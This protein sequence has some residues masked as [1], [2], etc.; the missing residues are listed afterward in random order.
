MKDCKK[1]RGSLAAYLCEDL[2]ADERRLLEQ[3]LET[4]PAC[5][6]ESIQMQ[7]VLEEADS[8]RADIQTAMASVDWRT[9]PDRISDKVFSETAPPA[10]L[11]RMAR[12]WGYIIQPRLRPVY[13]AL[14]IGV[15]LG[16]A[17]T[18]VVFRSPQSSDLAGYELIVPQKVL[19]AMDIEMARRETL[20]YL[21]K[22]Q[23]LLLD[24]VQSSPE[25]SRRSWQKQFTS[26]R[27]K[28][29]L[30]KKKYLNQQL[31]KF[32][33][34]KAKAICDQI[35]FLFFE[36]TQISDELS[37]AEIE[38][39]QKLIDERQLLLKIKLIQK[40]IEESEV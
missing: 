9:L 16:A 37:S 27:A 14:F 7:K 30:S 22:S 31:N 39:I 25:Y 28:E 20:D 40:E 5:Q 38:R 36:L 18:V 32:Q 34:A 8:L 23:Y 29:L 24:F 11:S 13:A 10:R 1:F 26:E 2:H 3:H 4:C 35:E 17:L 15:I 19:E 12:L 21:E 33:M 6:Q